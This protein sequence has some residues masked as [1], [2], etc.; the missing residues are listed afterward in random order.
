MAITPVRQCGSHLSKDIENCEKAAIYTFFQNHNIVNKPLN[1]T[2]SVLQ[3]FEIHITRP[4]DIVSILALYH[5]KERL[6]ELNNVEELLIASP[7]SNNA[8][9]DTHF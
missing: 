6:R 5:N 8:T 3:N 1:H 7:R 2:L 9:Q 4:H